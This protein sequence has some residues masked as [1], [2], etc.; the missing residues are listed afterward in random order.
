VTHSGFSYGRPILYDLHIRNSS[1][2]L[3]IVTKKRKHLQMLYVG[4]KIVGYLLSKNCAAHC[5]HLQN[6]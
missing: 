2:I 5:V 4:I 6:F 1:Y 3:W